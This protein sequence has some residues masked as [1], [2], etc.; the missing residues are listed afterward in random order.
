MIEGMKRAVKT[1]GEP[2]GAK[3]PVFQRLKVS[4][5]QLPDRTRRRA[6][7][8]AA[9]VLVILVTGIAGLLIWRSVSDDEVVFTPVL[10]S[11]QE[12]EKTLNE[13]NNT[14]PA[15]DT[16]IDEQVAYYEK[17]SFVKSEAGDTQGAIDALIKRQTI[18][19][20]DITYQTLLTLSGYYYQ[21]KDKKL[22]LETLD[23]AEA[24][25]P[26]TPNEA[27]GYTPEGKKA[28]IQELRDMYSKL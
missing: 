19:S 26:Q 5:Y 17:L 3:T 13:L 25:L 24:K 8:I 20:T 4:W 6:L 18:R 11:E 10:T 16:D 15:S 27:E 14:A 28:F 2:G 21:I 9:L 12:V 7:L 22:A 23:R 1:D